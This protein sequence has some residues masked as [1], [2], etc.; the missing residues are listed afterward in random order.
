MKIQN[1]LKN[2][3]RDIWY[4][5]KLRDNKHTVR[6]NDFFAVMSIPRI[7]NKLQSMYNADPNSLNPQEV[8]TLFSEVLRGLDGWKNVGFRPA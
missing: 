1:F 7:Q 2:N 6:K 8:S 4:W 3:S 5:V